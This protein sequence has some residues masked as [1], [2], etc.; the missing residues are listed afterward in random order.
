MV[1]TIHGFTTL[2]DCGYIATQFAIFM[3][4]RPL[5]VDQLTASL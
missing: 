2:L 5:A 3:F 4:T 1:A